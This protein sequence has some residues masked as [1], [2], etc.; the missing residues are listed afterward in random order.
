MAIDDYA[1]VVGIKSYPGMSSLEGP[2][3]DAEDFRGWLLRADGGDV[4]SNNIKY[5][6]TKC[7]H[8]PGPDAATDAKPMHQDVTS[9]F[10]DLVDSGMAKRVGR[11]LYI[12]MSGHGISDDRDMNKVS[13]C[14]AESDPPRLS[15]VAATGYA[16]WFRRN[17]SFDEIILIMDCCR[18]SNPLYSVT[19][20]QLPNTS[21]QLRAAKVRTFYCFAAGWSQRARERDFQGSVRGIFTRTLIQALDRAL[22]NNKNQVTD[23]TVANMVHNLI[24]EIAGD[25]SVDPPELRTSTRGR[26][27]F[28]EGP[29]PS[30]ISV[31][32]DPNLPGSTIIIHDGSREEVLRFPVGDNDNR[33]QLLPG[34]YKA[35]VEGT[36]RTKFF[37]VIESDEEIRF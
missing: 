11:R 26:I 22:T 25:V 4:P 15:E 9:I 18:T 6:T 8:P 2:C 17:G 34:I 12:Y 32:L 29:S 16:D 36:P 14:T 23:Q 7:F 27:V 10:S 24:D 30:N 31:C 13:L 5:L 28:A 1:V 37:E 35:M 21:D 20:P 3:D 19:S 33:I